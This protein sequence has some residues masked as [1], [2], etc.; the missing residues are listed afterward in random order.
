MLGLYFLGAVEVGNGAGDL[1]DAAVGTGRVFNPSLKV[2]IV[3]DFCTIVLFLI[4][5]VLKYTFF[6]VIVCTFAAE[7]R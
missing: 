2:E 5:Y 7:L 1:Q 4:Q 3:V 6:F